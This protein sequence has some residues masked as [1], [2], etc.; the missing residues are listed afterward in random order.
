MILIFLIAK[1]R[2]EKIAFIPLSPPFPAR[3][4]G[5]HSEIRKEI[6]SPLKGEGLGGVIMRFL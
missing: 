1:G 4:E 5:K 3:R 2:C 6:P